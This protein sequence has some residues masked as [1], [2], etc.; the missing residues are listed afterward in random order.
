MYIYQ[1]LLKI[2]QM[3]SK[4]YRFWY[5]KNLTAYS[6]WRAVSPTKTPCFRDSLLGLAP[7]SENPISTSVMFNLIITISTNIYITCWRAPTP[8]FTINKTDHDD[9]N[10]LGL[11]SATN[12]TIPLSNI[13]V[14]SFFVADEYIYIYI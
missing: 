9:Q 5:F 10:V 12:K 7:L 11:L 2:H 4:L 3:R 14:I 8:T 13:I 1:Y 6:F